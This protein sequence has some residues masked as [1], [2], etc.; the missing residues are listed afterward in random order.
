MITT[1][2]PDPGAAA[3]S[4]HAVEPPTGEAIFGAHAI[5]LKKAGLAVVPAKGK[6]PIRKHFDKMK[7][8]PGLAI[9]ERWAETNAG[10]NIVY[11]PGLSR[12]RRNR[13]GVVVVD[14]D[15]AAEIE[16]A[17][18]SFGKT[19]AMID[20]RRGRH[21]IY[22]APEG[23]LGRIG[24]LRSFGIEIDIKHGQKGFG[25]SVAPPSRHPDQVDFVYAWHTG[26]GLG[27]LAELPTFNVK[28]FDALIVSGSKTL[29]NVT[30]TAP[31]AHL[32]S[33][34]KSTT[35]MLGKA[36]PALFRDGSRKLGL[37]DHLVAH[38]WAIDDYN[39]CLDIARTWNDHLCETSGIEQ[40]P[41]AEVIEVCRRVM[42]DLGDGK[43]VRTHRQRAIAI[44]DADEVRRMV[45]LYENGTD[46][47]AFLLLLRAEHRARCLRGET[48]ALCV[49]SMVGAQTM[50][51]WAARKYRA[52]RDTLLD[53]GL[54]EKVAEARGRRAA[55]YR[56]SKRVLTP[57]VASG[58]TSQPQCES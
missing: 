18:M 43:L 8:A 27:S 39:A 10:D 1:N 33:N 44:T 7:H 54:I 9:V 4:A 17:E 53:A 38:A 2:E 51:H 22:R 25:I 58:K 45:S 12:S 28:A 32:G 42:A 52:V 26:S 50:G 36:F 16:R 47:L 34:A 13:Y 24:S 6:R 29:P 30:K 35:R 5:A 55:Q 56:L 41:D 20:T 31:A 57:S 46:A 23:S 49:K 14:A 48:F 3:P 11:I 15:N 19:P 37:N 21:F 40:L